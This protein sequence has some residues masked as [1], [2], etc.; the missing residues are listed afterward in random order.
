MTNL[1]I[2]NYPITKNRCYIQNVKRKPIGIQI[3]S[4][5][6][7][8]GTAKA[9]CDYWNQS[10]V[11]CCTTYIC[12]A[13]EPGK[14]YKMVNE[15]VYTWADAGYGNRN[16]ITIEIAESDF[17][18]YKG[19]AEYD[20]LDDFRFVSDI[21]RGY[22]TA[23]LLCADICKRYGWKP[24]T[25][26]PSG[27]YLISSHDEG[28]IKGLSSGH[29]D[30]THIWPRIQK[31]MDMFRNDVEYAMNDSYIATQYS[32]KYYRIR[33]TWSDESSQLGAYQSLDKAKAACPYGYFVFDDN[34][35]AIY[36][37]STIP[38]GTQASDFNDL[39][40]DMAAEMILA[41]I[42]ECDDSGILY[43]VTAAQMILESGYVT[44]RLSK[45]AN[46]CFGMKE[47]LS[48]NTWPN[49]TWDGVSTVAVNTH[50][51]Y[52]GMDYVITAK[53]RKYKKIEDSIKDHAAYLLGA[54]NGSKKRYEGL[55]NANN[56]EEAITIIKNGGYA[57]DPNYISKILSIIKRFNLDRYDN[58]ITK[59]KAKSAKPYRVQIG[60]FSNESNAKA[61]VKKI[62]EL[63]FP[64][65]KVKEGDEWVVYSSYFKTE[66]E[67]RVRFNDLLK[68]GISSFVKR[69]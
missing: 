13:D 67:A 41:L 19:G 33:K 44:T 9:V 22:D 20:I 3:H 21:K 57:T 32:D 37:N 26:L 46:N 12:D 4:I 65:R 25:K 51:V 28:R 40:E 29:V 49:S 7:A 38:D 42:H 64:C 63:N 23:V 30:P 11:S 60:V 61:C 55:L 5:G 36:L 43:S 31:N 48:N 68:A 16:L 14:V 53:F 39:S 52:N 27:L 6:T 47:G 8:Q 54:T 66:K 59:G 50:E 24:H 69:I 18:R 62:K 17:M 58:E 34:G 45:L 15:D 35:K 10:G 56:A 1:N 2:I